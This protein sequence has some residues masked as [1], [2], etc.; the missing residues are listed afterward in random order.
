MMEV[1]SDTI[2]GWTK[3][4]IGQ[5]ALLTVPCTQRLGIIPIGGKFVNK[6]KVN[7]EAR[8]GLCICRP[9]ISE[10][11]SV[12][13]LFFHY[14]WPKNGFLRR[15]IMFQILRCACACHPAEVPFPSVCGLVPVLATGNRNFSNG[16]ESVTSGPQSE[17]R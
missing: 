2:R 3:Y 16:I 6:A 7:G 13:V 1:T 8:K 5:S 15:E 4:Q 14:P 10:Q 17:G 11:T 12:Y 9:P